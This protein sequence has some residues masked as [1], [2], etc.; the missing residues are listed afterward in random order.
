MKIKLFQKLLWL[1]ALSF[2]LI[3][4]KKNEAT[5]P[6]DPYAPVTEGKVFLPVLVHKPDMEK[7]KK[8]EEG[9]NGH[10]EK[11]KPDAEIHDLS[12]NLYEFS[13]TGMDVKNV[14]YYINK[15]SGV[16]V[17]AYLEIEH[18]ALSKITDLSKKH[19]FDDSHF[20]A[21]RHSG[22]ARG[23]DEGVFV[24]CADWSRLSFEQFGKQPSAM[25]A[26]SKIPDSDYIKNLLEQK[27]DYISNLE[28]ARGSE[29]FKEHKKQSGINKGQVVFAIFKLNLSEMP[30]DT[31]ITYFFYWEEGA[32]PADR[33]GKC[34]K[35]DY[36]FKEPSLGY[37]RD[38]ISGLVIPT[39]EFLDLCK[40]TGYE[41]DSLLS[42]EGE[43]FVNQAAGLYMVSERSLFDELYDSND[44]FAMFFLK[45]EDGGKATESKSLGLNTAKQPR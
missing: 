26:V 22:L 28:R 7:V 33:L 32:A 23:G 37:Y 15:D 12:C 41:W 36:Y 42:H 14:S 25:P 35:I 27:Y 13:Y 10:L 30:Q 11:I 1:L 39:Q 9:R 5:K 3:A 20:L 38:K 17:G 4:C 24:F 43:R 44:C 40:N 18:E 2:G 21:K 29:L 6:I 31:Y 16:L 8:V 34:H 45:K 19:G